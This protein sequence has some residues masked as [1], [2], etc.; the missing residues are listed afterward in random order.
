[1]VSVNSGGCILFDKMEGRGFEPLF[2]SFALFIEIEP[3]VVFEKLVNH[4]W[5]PE[6]I[7]KSYL[8]KKTS[9][10]SLSRIF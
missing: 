5:S 10:Y 4:F 1:M 3:D 7:P 2:N 8:N 9:D 6:M